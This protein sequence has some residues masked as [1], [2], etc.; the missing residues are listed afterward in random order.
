[1]TGYAKLSR[2]VL[3]LWRAHN[4]SSI[5]PTYKRYCLDH[6]NDY[7]IAAELAWHYDPTA[8]DAHRTQAN[9]HLRDHLAHDYALPER[10]EVR[11]RDFWDQLMTTG[12][13]TRTKE[14]TR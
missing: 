10:H 2:S 12:T 8:E 3:A 4:G 9:E 11:F 14:G 7:V 5:E 6:I 13:T 1:M